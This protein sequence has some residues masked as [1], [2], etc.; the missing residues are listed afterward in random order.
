VLEYATKGTALTYRWTNVVDG[1]DMPVRVTV[2][3]S[4]MLLRPTTSPQTARVASGSSAVIVDP[5]FF[6]TAH[7]TGG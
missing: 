6:V 5:S 7:R 1:F 4:P 2:G 3:K